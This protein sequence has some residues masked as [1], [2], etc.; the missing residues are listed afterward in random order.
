VAGLLAGAQL[1]L[2]RLLLAGAEDAERDLGALSALPDQGGELLGV[3]EELILEVGEDVVLAE[4]AVGGAARVDLEDNEAGFARQSKLGAEHG[5]RGGD[6][7]PE[8][9]DTFALAGGAGRAALGPAGSGTGSAAHFGARPG[10]TGVGFSGREGGKD[11]GNEEREGA[12]ECFHW[13]MAWGRPWWPLR[14]RTQ[15]RGKGLRAADEA[16]ESLAS[17]GANGSGHHA[18]E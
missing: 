11:E 18:R 13:M 2:E 5:G 10:G 7:G 9:G 8:E 4:H 17:A 6:G 12:E 16:N 15:G 1:D 14:A 3:H